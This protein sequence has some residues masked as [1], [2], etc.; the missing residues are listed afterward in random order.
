MSNLPG[1]GERRRAI[2]PTPESASLLLISLLGFRGPLL[3]QGFR[4]LLLG[5][6]LSFVTLAHWLSFAFLAPSLPD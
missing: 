2:L 1:R 6:F 4:R 5:F 3:H